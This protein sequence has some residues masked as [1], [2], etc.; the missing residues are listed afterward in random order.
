VTLVSSIGRAGI[1]RELASVMCTER[2]L[3]A[4][5]NIDRMNHG[6]VEAG[7]RSMSIYWE[8][9]ML[10][11]VGLMFVVV[12]LIGPAIAMARTQTKSKFQARVV[13]KDG[14]SEDLTAARKKL[15][16]DKEAEEKFASLAKSTRTGGSCY[17]CH[18][19]GSKKPHNAF[20]WAAE[21][22]I[23]R[24]DSPTLTKA[25]VEEVFK[26]KDTDAKN[27][28]GDHFA[29]AAIE[30]LDYWVIVN[31][32]GELELTKDATDDAGDPL[33]FGQ[34]IRKGNLPTTEVKDSSFES[35]FSQEVLDKLLALRPEDE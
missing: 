26:G 21:R 34:R 28:L 6:L 11:N 17:V 5:V 13:A 3:I 9:I 20:G 14:E 2:N 19:K 31:D 27:E 15:F 25:Q 10:R 32:D 33:T 24:K 23:M 8:F 22:L 18:Q 1:L 16:E 35:V 12:A 29:D 30:A 7:S 4:S